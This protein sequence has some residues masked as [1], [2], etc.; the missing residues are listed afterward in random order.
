MRW[1]FV[2]SEAIAAGAVRKHELRARF[3][4]LYPDVYVPNGVE[5][6]LPQRATAAWL[7]SHR[8]GVI[9]GP[10]ASAL[11]GAKWVDDSDPVELVWPNA[12]PPR[13]IRTHDARLRSDEFGRLGGLV[14]T[15]PARTAFDLGR[16]KPLGQAVARLDA[17]GNATGLT[18]DEVRA[19]AKQH[20]WTSTIR[21]PRRR[22]KPGCACW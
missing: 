17:L 3:V 13:G 9:A 6:T 2:G 7:W 12:R 21:G 15:T 1:P 18:A 16:R 22:R 19:V 5:P 8:Q 20:R 14:A 4:A 11:H 10:T